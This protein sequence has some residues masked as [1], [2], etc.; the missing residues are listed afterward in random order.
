[1]AGPFT[2]RSTA[3]TTLRD[4]AALRD[5]PVITNDFTGEMI[6]PLLSTSAEFLAGNS[7][8]G[9]MRL[10]MFEADA[11]YLAGSAFSASL[12]FPMFSNAGAFGTY[13]YA[14]DWT[15]PMF[16]AAGR[17]ESDIAQT[18][19]GWP[20]NLK[21]MGLTEYQNFAFN[22]MT[23]FNGEYLAAGAGGLFSLDGDDDNGTPID[24]RVRF[25]LTDFGIEALKRLEEAFVSYR[26]AGDLRFRV[27]I[28]GGETYEYTLA[29]TG[30]TGIATN[31]AKVG[32]AIKS[33]Y[34]CLE[35]ESVAGIPFE[36]DAIKLHPVVLDRKIGRPPDARLFTGRMRFP[37]FTGSGQFAAS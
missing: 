25:A 2:L 10:P 19:R 6:F 22:S 34:F 15:L 5:G 27:I 30:N 21:N 20:I 24:S 8:T 7:F 12:N 23:R 13:V 31:R 35:V 36:L 32:K 18:Y 9:S 1:M 26:S 11:D 14:G 3:A 29:A 33:N 37:M 4:S 16:V 28:D 17:A